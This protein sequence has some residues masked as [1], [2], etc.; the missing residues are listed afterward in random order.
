MAVN[1]VQLAD[2][3]VLIDTTSVT[4]DAEHLASG[5]TA[6][7]KAGTKITGTANVDMNVTVYSGDVVNESLIL[8]KTPANTVT[9]TFEF[10]ST[11]KGTAQDISLPYS[12]NGYPISVMVFPSDGSY[13][14]SADIYTRVQQYGCLFYTMNK[15]RQSGNYAAPTYSA[16]N[17]SDYG[18]VHARIKSDSATATTYG[19]STAS[20]AKVY[21]NTAAS[22]SATLILKFNSKTQMSVF[23]A[24]SSY[25]FFDGIEYRY[26]ILYS[27]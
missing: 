8:E 1:K 5:Y 2:G 23:V 20:Q 16:S 4:V 6:L 9:G 26:V 27:E 17:Y 18:F 11:A 15:S 3:T 10:D 24:D 13:N 22:A 14:P 12:G 19:N 25:G 7:N 21:A